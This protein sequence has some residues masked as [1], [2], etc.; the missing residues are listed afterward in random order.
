MPNSGPFQER[1]ASTF[2]IS[3]PLN[4]NL[5]KPAPTQTLSIE[6]DPYLSVLQMKSITDQYALSE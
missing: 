3:Q 4:A 2:A 5:N 1:V 6:V